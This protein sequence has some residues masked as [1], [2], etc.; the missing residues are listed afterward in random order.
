MELS[1]RDKKAAVLILHEIL[2]VMDECF[3][4]GENPLSGDTA[5]TVHERVKE[6]ATAS[7]GGIENSNGSYQ[8][9][10]HVFLAM[11]DRERRRKSP[12]PEIVQ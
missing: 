7:K 5:F 4:R 3:G 1:E 10:V 2:N 11:A 9:L 6:M 8:F 12:E